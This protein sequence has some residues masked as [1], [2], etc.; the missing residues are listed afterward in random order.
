MHQQEICKNSLEPM[1]S[2]AFVDSKIS[3][4]KQEEELLSLLAVFSKSML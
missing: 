4:R 1:I 3:V 2:L